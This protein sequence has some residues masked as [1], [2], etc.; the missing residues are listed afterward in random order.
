MSS[1][2][3]SILSCWVSVFSSRIASMDLPPDGILKRSALVSNQPRMTAFQRLALDAVAL[4]RIEPGITPQGSDD[5]PQAAHFGEV[6]ERGGDMG[7][8]R[9]GPGSLARLLWL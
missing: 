1:L 9:I 3:T 8:L 5:R 4:R 7:V 2:L 6:P